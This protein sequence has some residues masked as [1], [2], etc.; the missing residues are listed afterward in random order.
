M[1][2]AAQLVVETAVPEERHY[3]RRATV[4]ICENIAEFVTPNGVSVN[5]TDDGPQA[6]VVA[7]HFNRES[8]FLATMMLAGFARYVPAVYPLLAE[9]AAELAAT[10]K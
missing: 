6:L 3:I 1:E 10:R 8:A 5:I 4:N 2:A 7:V 9:A